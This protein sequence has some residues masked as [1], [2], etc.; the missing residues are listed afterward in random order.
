MSP[1][2]SKAARDSFSSFKMPR[3]RWNFMPSKACH[4]HSTAIQNS[5]FSRHNWPTF[6]ST[7]TSSIRA[8]IHHLEAAEEDSAPGAAIDPLG[9]LGEHTELSPRDSFKFGLCPQNFRFDR[10]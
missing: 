3:S 5:P 7:A 9:V 8:R 10:I 2:R 6:L 4:M 1:F